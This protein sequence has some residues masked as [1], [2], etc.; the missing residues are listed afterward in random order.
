M[1]EPTTK[2][3]NAVATCLSYAIGFEFSTLAVSDFVALLRLSPSWS[4]DEAAEV[5]RLAIDGLAERASE[6]RWS[7]EVRS[8]SSRS[9]Q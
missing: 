8:S 2:I 1:G 9:D 5:H 6:A 7:T 4:Q 3:S